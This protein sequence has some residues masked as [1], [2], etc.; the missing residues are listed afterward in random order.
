[1]TNNERERRKR[2][3]EAKESKRRKKR[4]GKQ[5]RKVLIIGEEK[6][7]EKKSLKDESVGKFEPPYDHIG[8]WG[9]GA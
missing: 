3:K 2:R 4:Q 7:V 8:R 5:K 1:M 6:K 9:W